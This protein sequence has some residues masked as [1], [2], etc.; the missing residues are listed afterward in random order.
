MYQICRN[1]ISAG[2]RDRSRNTADHHAIML[3]HIEMFDLQ[4]DGPRWDGDDG[5]R[6]DPLKHL[7]LCGSS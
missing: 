3:I 1:K 4:G 5:R 7:A 6:S 2:A